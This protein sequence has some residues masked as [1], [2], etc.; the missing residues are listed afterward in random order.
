M[1][2]EKLISF[3][4]RADCG[5]L[6]K[7]DYNEGMLLTYN[8]LHKPALLGTLG[9]IIGL[10]GYRKKGELP[11]YYQLLKDIPVGIAP[12]VGYHEKGNFKKTAVKYSN[13]VGYANKDGNL[14]VEETMLLKPAYRCF[15]LLS[16]EN[17]EQVKLY[18]FLQAGEAEYIP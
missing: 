1:A 4:L 11:E 3:D 14:L 12:L 8:M 17:K 16:L 15:L 6:K 5:F 2:Q 9:A 10:E 7:P 13:T 18:E